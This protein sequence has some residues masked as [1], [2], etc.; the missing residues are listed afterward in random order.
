M[1]AN[2]L[3]EC[4]FRSGQRHTVTVVG[5]DPVYNCHIIET[6][7]GKRQFLDSKHCAHIKRVRSGKTPRSR[8]ACLYLLEIGDGVYKAGCTRNLQQRIRAAKTFCERVQ[9]VATREL[10]ARHAW[11]EYETRFMSILTQLCKS[12]GQAGKEVFV[13][14]ANAAKAAARMM[15]RI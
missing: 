1:L 9:V 6:D 4:V 15:Q 11:R 2:G 14:E 3:H 5:Y 12:N 13:M 8:P 7:R 10:K